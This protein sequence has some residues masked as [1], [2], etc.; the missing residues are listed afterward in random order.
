VAL[1]TDW[2][3]TDM[4]GMCFD[5][6]RGSVLGVDKMYNFGSVCA[7]VFVYKNVALN[8]KWTGTV[9]FLSD[10]YSF[11]HGCSDTDTYSDFYRS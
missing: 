11:I 8:S 5:K 10:Q 1:Y 4:K 2:Q 7:T 3:L 6:Q 9:P